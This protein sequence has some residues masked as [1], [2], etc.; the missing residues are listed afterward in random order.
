VLAGT[1]IEFLDLDPVA[2]GMK[3]L[4]TSPYSEPE[5]RA[6]ERGDLDA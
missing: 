3:D 4:Y 5:V 1:A 6:G 2:Y